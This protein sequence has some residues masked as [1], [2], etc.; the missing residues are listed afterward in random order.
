MAIEIVAATR[1]QWWTFESEAL[2]YATMKRLSFDKRIE[3]RIAAGNSRGLPIIY[4]ERLLEAK[5]G[6]ILVFTHDDVWI[7]DV[8]LADRLND[9]L[10]RFDVIGVA[11]TRK[12]GFRQKGWAIDENGNTLAADL[13]S[14]MVPHGEPSDPTYFYF[15]PSPAACELMDGVFLAARK[16]TLIEAGVSFDTRF[17][18]HFYDLDFCR[19]ARAKGLKL[20]T[21]PIAITHGSLGN[22]FSPRWEQMLALYREKW[23]D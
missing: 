9:A 14:G 12:Q 4:N 8:F 23:P 18:F 17:D 1:L 19:T 10:A 2:L 16:D 3:F 5:D 7:D 15:G 11:G 6:D 22:F 20:G 21:W 13:L